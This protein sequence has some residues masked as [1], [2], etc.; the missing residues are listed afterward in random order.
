MAATNLT[1]SITCGISGK[2]CEKRAI[3]KAFVVKTSS[4]VPSSNYIGA[5]CRKG[6]RS[7]NVIRNCGLASDQHALEYELG[8]SNVEERLAST[9]DRLIN[10]SND[11]TM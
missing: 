3:R 5:I 6:S 1:G 9:R 2:N 10:G 8:P 4:K 7:N 11:G